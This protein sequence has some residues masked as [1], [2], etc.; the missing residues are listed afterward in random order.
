MTLS[1]LLQLPPEYI[2]VLRQ[3]ASAQGQN[4]DA[5]IS[6]IVAEEV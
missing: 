2:D 5:Y 4:L 6:H 3:R 1:I